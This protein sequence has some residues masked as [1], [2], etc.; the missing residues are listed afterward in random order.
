MQRDFHILDYLYRAG[1]IL[2]V[3][4]AACMAC[5]AQ[6]LLNS[7]SAATGSDDRSA[8]QSIGDDCV[9]FAKNA[10]KVFSA[11]AHF[12]GGEWVITG[13]AAGGVGL[14]MFADEP[15]RDFLQR[16]RNAGVSDALQVGYYYGHV[17]TPA[18]LAGVL[19]LG[20]L[21]SGDDELR[22][23]GL[24]V[25]EAAAFAGIFTSAVK[26]LAGRSRPFLDEGAFRYRWFQTNDDHLS[27]PSGHTT[28]AFAVSTVLSRRIDHPVATIV[29]YLLAATTVVQRMYDDRHWL[30]D[31]VAG[32][33][34]GYVFGKAVSDLH[35]ETGNS[36]A[37]ESCLIDAG[38]P[39]GLR[40]G[41]SLG[42]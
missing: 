38:S 18:I 36:S 40:V 13:A 34:I 17:A 37:S 25:A 39:A 5:T 12:G 28:V 2:L 20:G 4:L 27:F 32:S 31:A 11:P 10:G 15:L 23:T 29:L 1:F 16:N 26:S 24:M 19:Y 22:E 30:S 33:I 9:V 7:A 35:A 6:D 42:F 8:W 3:A 41:V 14:A 21:A